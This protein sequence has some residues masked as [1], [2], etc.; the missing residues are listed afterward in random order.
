MLA[1]LVLLVP[2]TVVLL[3]A[4]R[5][6]GR[7]ESAPGSTYTLLQMNLCLSGRAG[8]FPRVQ[9]PLGVRQA[10]DVIRSSGADA[11][12]LNE[13]CR[14]DVESI[15]AETGYQ[16]RFAAVPSYVLGDDCIDPGGRGVYGIAVLTKSNVTASAERPFLAQDPSME[17]RHWLCVTTAQA[18]ICSTHLEI[19]GRE[20]LDTVNDQQC[21]EFAAVLARQ[22]TDRPVV[23]GGDL[24]RDE[25]CAA[26]GMWVQTDRA[27]A[28]APGKQHAYGT[29]Q[30]EL[31]RT[32]IVPFPYSDHDVM[33]ITA[34]LRS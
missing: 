2:L 22:A 13:I 34:D 25:P 32:T 19:R 15:A 27:A 17:Q 6:G 8:C 7:S 5:E 31:P 3:L 20:R 4:A 16:A 18:G 28:Q 26:P 14:S 21:I 24:N 11:V 1:G 10:V 23:A 12:T 33:I 30:F 29:R 9:Y